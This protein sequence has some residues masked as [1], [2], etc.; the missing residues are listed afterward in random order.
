MVDA[1]PSSTP[2]IST[3]APAP[4]DNPT[5]AVVDAAVPATADPAAP[6]T[7]VNPVVEAKEQIKPASTVLGDALDKPIDKV[8]QAPVDKAE[9]KEIESSQSDEPAPLPTYDEF[10]SPDDYLLDK[11]L[12]GD[13]AKSLGEFELLSKADHAA[14]Q[15]FGQSLVERHVAEVKKTVETINQTYLDTWEAQK[16]SW[17]ESF[18]KDSEIG[19]NRQETTLNAARE[20]IRAHGGNDTQQKELRDLINHTGVGNHPA[21]IRLLAQ[22]GR[23]KEFTEG[24]PLPA[25]AP[26]LSTKDKIA[27]RYGAS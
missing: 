16:L 23:S 15:Q 27:K 2:E 26:A 24:K 25:T 17:R 5:P 13:F 8:E 9:P 20:F 22:A 11:E 18:E 7:D 19:G 4:V 6:I 21:F 3:P 10:K 12:I 14:V 1:T